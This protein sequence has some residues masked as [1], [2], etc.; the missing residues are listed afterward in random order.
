MVMR[1]GGGVRHGVHLGMAVART[2]GVNRHQQQVRHYHED[3]HAAGRRAMEE[4]DP[5]WRNHIFE[6]VGGVM[7][8]RPKGDNVLGDITNG[9]NG[10]PVEQEQPKKP[11]PIM[12]GYPDGTVE[13]FNKAGKLTKREFPDGK[14]EYFD[15]MVEIKDKVVEKGANHLFVYERIPVD[16]AQVP[17]QDKKPDVSE[18][19]SNEKLLVKEYLE[20]C[21]I[22]KGDPSY[23]SI[24]SLF[25]S[26]VTMSSL[27][28]SN[29][30]FKERFDKAKNSLA[31][32]YDNY[33]NKELEASDPDSYKQRKEIHRM[34]GEAI[35]KMDSNQFTEFNDQLSK[36]ADLIEKNDPA[37]EGESNNIAKQLVQLMADRGVNSRIRDLEKIV[38]VSDFEDATF[39]SS[40]AITKK[41][42][43]TRNSADD[44]KPSSQQ[45]LWKAAIYAIMGSTYLYLLTHECKKESLT[46]QI[47]TSFQQLE[48]LT[49]TLVKL[50]SE[51]EKLLLDNFKGA[52]L[53]KEKAKKAFASG[54]KD[55]QKASLVEVEKYQ[56]SFK[57]A[58][59]DMEDI[60]HIQTECAKL[61]ESLREL[62]Q[63]IE[64]D[65]IQFP[66]IN[67]KS[68]ISNPSKVVWDHFPSLKEL[69]E[70]NATT[71]Q[72]FK[73]RNEKLKQEC[74][75]LNALVEKMQ[76]IPK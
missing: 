17:K 26:F 30:L 48:H 67:P 36:L 8:A 63:D 47:N 38:S 13:Y 71:L 51:K 22:K 9:N 65:S 39:S 31:D 18:K 2:Q 14:V 69:D 49:Q 10:K 68:I 44:A 70:K 59:K 50:I 7:L 4:G 24:K 45:E 62:K 74:N 72:T 60:Q 64:G 76:V 40:L 58:Q 42:Q 32:C 1:C 5:N 12:I 19:L 16:N 34:M 37:N 54:K 28:S 11:H 75:T 53:A 56:K 52:E 57:E 33:E 61:D 73:D 46:K 66:D 15:K 20:L 55:E 6:D 23:N 35:R 21:G 25:K 3:V 41:I 29:I 43:S 27:G